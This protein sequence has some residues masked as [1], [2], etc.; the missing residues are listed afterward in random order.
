[1]LQRVTV[2]NNFKWSKISLTMIRNIWILAMKYPRVSLAIMPYKKWF[3][4]SFILNLYQTT[5]TNLTSKWIVDFNSQR[6]DFCVKQDKMA[7]NLKQILPTVKM[8][9]ST[10]NIRNGCLFLT[11]CE[12][13]MAIC[14]TSLTAWPILI[15]FAGFP[16]IWSHAEYNA[17]STSATS[18][19]LGCDLSLGSQ[20][21]SISAIVNSRTRMRPDLGEI[22]FRKE[23]PTCAAAKG[24][25]PWRC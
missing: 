24:S 9:K 11:F 16:S 17:A 2:I 22:S 13:N 25:L 19:N 21:C 6:L 23:F 7:Q 18:S 1:M 12:W 14:L 3:C 15:F 8:L 20:K 5:T 10:N 4:E